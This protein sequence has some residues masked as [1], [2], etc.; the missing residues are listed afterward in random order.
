MHLLGGPVAVS[1]PPDSWSRP[2][3]DSGPSTGSAREQLAALQEELIA[4]RATVAALESRIARLESF[5]AA[6]GLS[7]GDALE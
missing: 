1:T 6:E 2:L 7:P 3:P 5:H 4:M